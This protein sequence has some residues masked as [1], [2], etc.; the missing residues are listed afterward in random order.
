MTLKEIG[1]A[2]DP[3]VSRQRIQQILGTTG[4]MA[5]KTR[6]KAVQEYPREMTDAEVAEQTGMSVDYVA[7][8]RRQGPFRAGDPSTSWGIGTQ[9]VFLVSKRLEE[10]GIEHSIVG[11]RYPYN[12]LA[13]TDQRPYRIRVLTRATTSQPPTHR[14]NPFYSFF[15]RGEKDGFDLLIAVA[16]D[17]EVCYI[18]PTGIVAPGRSFRIVSKEHGSKNKYGVYEEAWDQLA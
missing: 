18:I 5:S 6:V 3:P 15:E 13:F 16:L 17:I 12:I 1:A 9:G 2:E 8:I 4:F 14:G 10:R 11:Y 7:E